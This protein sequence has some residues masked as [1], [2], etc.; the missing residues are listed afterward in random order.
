VMTKYYEFRGRGEYVTNQQWD[1][2]PYPE[3]WLTVQRSRNPLR[4]V[5]GCSDDPGPH[6]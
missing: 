2:E 1:H 4:I 6:E 3:E 5:P